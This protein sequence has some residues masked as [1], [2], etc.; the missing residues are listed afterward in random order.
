M[1]RMIL[2]GGGSSS[3]KSYLTSR[4]LQNIGPDS[5]TRITIDDYYKDQKDMT[6]EESVAVIYYH[7]IA[8]D[9][10]LFRR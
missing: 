6:E 4:V 2:V 3:G 7:L 8:F 10:L 9:W 5:V 1:P